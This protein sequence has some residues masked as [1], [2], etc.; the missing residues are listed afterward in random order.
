MTFY[1]ELVSHQDSFTFLTLKQIFR[2]I[3][4]DLL[5]L[6]QLVMDGFV[7]RA[8]MGTHLSL[9]LCCSKYVGFWMESWL[10]VE[11]KTLYIELVSHYLYLSHT[12]TQIFRLIRKNII[13][14]FQLSTRLDKILEIYLRCQ[15]TH[16]REIIQ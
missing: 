13:Q 10:F 5:Q 1:K 16:A 9:G 8:S 2:F 3:W 11:P 7:I 15:D 6:F 14:L 12:Q 4:K